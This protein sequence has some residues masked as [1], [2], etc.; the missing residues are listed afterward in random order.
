MDVSHDTIKNKDLVYS[1]SAPARQSRQ[2]ELTLEVRHEFRENTSIHNAFYE[3]STC[4]GPW[5]V[6][7]RS[8]NEIPWL[9]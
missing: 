6:S 9:W 4:L 5:I 7:N 8:R 1:N 3:R 2:E